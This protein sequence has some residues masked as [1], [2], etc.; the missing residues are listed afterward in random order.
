MIV[1]HQIIKYPLSL[2]PSCSLLKT[3]SSTVAKDVKN[4]CSSQES[5]KHDAVGAGSQMLQHVKASPSPELFLSEPLHFAIM[6]V[7]LE[8]SFVRL[9]SRADEVP[10]PYAKRGRKSNP[11]S[12]AVVI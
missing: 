9:K 2:D 10:F 11:H 1:K 8:S 5:A 7:P 12:K 3:H 4:T 6:V